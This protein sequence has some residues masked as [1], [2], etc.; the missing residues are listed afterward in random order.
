MTSM[1]AVNGAIKS[2]T[3]REWKVGLINNTQKYLTAE[4]FGFKIN[5]TGTA[6]KKKQIFSLVEDSE[7]LICIRSNLGRYLSGDKYGN[8]TCEAEEIGQSE[9]F[10][11]EYAKDNSGRWAFR[12]VLHGLYLGCV[13]EIP[14]F[15]SS[16]SENELWTI[17]LSIHPMVHM[18]NVHRKRYVHLGEN[19]LQITQ[20][21]PWGIKPFLL[22]EY[23]DGKYAI[24]T[25]DN[26]Y[27]KMNGELSHT[28][29]EDGRYNLEIRTGENGGLVFQ[30]KSGCYLTGV[31]STAIMKGRMK[32]VGKDELFTLDETHPSVR[33]LS[34]FNKKVSIKQGIF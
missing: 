8:V 25:Y 10:A 6:L 3:E 27:L 26:R 23:V 1:S 31:G 19:E 7:E 20:V 4:T 21:I 29:S 18:R 5:V 16:V 34:Y 30:D 11:I 22:L 13:N 15:A 28:L 12:N 33:L 9:R 24:K 14:K 2:G 17:Q 32:Q